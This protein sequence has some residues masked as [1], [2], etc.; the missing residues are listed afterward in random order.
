[1]AGALRHLTEELGALEAAGLLRRPHVADRG[2]LNFCSNDYLGYAAEP[3]PPTGARSGAGASRLVSGSD[4]AHA[5]AEVALAEWLGAE[6]A[7]L[8][9]SG[10]VANVATVAALV[11]PDDVVFSDALNHASL[12]DGCRL[13]GARVQVFRHLDVEAL[14]RALA[15]A[16]G[17]RRR[18]V[19]TE[20]YFSM[21]GDSPDLAAYRTLC[22][23][24]DAA[25]VVDEAHALGVF[26]PAGRGVCAA[27]G[28]RADVLIGTA[29]KALGLQ[30]AFVAGSRELREW[31]WNRG[32]GF[33]FS[34]GM[35]PA[36]AEALRIRVA[37]A[38]ADDA[39]RVRLFDA[40]RRIREA[41]APHGVGGGVG[42]IVPWL[43]GGV[44]RAL[45]VAESL[46]GDG[47][48]VH[49]IRP[50]TVAAGGARLRFT[51]RANL[52]DG[53]LARLASAL[54]KVGG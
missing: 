37:R 52:T 40:A 3:L 54:A 15:D 25:L 4:D 16:G 33:V 22:D 53:D 20:S 50:P 19:V 17:M 13:S 30:G 29:G 5:G 32:R 23:R 38:R 35:S 8:F 6:A 42:P 21:D 9:S 36:L 14:A 27:S 48:L 7:L 10:F 47:V 1:M 39:G 46:R 51:A 24:S 34:T 43:L 31:L 28:V 26:G 45:A 18:W 41:L 2:L 49:A 12:I 44:N 11:G